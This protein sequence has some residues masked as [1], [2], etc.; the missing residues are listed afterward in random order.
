MK[1]KLLS[2]VIICFIGSMF[3]AGCGGKEAAAPAEDPQPEQEISEDQTPPTETPVPETNETDDEETLPMSFFLQV[4]SPDMRLAKL[5]KTK[6]Y[7][8]TSF[9]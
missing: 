3:I 4:T 2:T 9:M 6:P 5:K 8:N 7:P 1:R